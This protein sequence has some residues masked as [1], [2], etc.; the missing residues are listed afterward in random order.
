MQGSSR[1][2]AAF[3][4]GSVGR[5]DCPN[6]L[7][8]LYRRLKDQAQMTMDDFLPGR[9]STKGRHGTVCVNLAP[10]GAPHVDQHTSIHDVLDYISVFFEPSSP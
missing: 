9:A 7:K 2:S 5:P 6:A 4:E 8:L 1:P 10:N 3:S